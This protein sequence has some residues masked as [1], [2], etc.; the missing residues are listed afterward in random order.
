[1]EETKILMRLAKEIMECMS[2]NDLICSIVSHSFSLEDTKRKIVA[3]C[4]RIIYDDKYCNWGRIVTACI[5]ALEVM[6]KYFSINKIM[7]LNN[8]YIED[9]TQ[10]IYND[11]INITW[12]EK[13][14]N[15]WNGFIQCFENK[16]CV[17]I[18]YMVTYLPICMIFVV[19]Y[20][21]WLNRKIF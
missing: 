9:I 18:D 2:S 14:S 5:F 16:K 1:M 11:I 19:L 7:I 21:Y 10:W 8:E 15:G 20:I 12:I 6:R 4:K 3:V 17:F 13:Q